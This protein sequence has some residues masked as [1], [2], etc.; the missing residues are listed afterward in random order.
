MT[1]SKSPHHDKNAQGRVLD[2]A[3]RAAVVQTRD[4]TA[5]GVHTQVLTRLVRAGSLERVGPGRYRLA[6]AAVTKHH[7]LVLASAAAASGVI[8]LLSALQFHNIGTQLPHQVWIAVPTGTRVPRLSFPPLR[9]VRISSATFSQGIEGHRLEGHAVRV[10][11]LT[12]TVAD[13]FRF[14][15]TIGL[16]VALEALKEAWRSGR[17]NLDELHRV[18]KQLRV[19]RVMQPYLE[20]IVL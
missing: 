2:L 8:C 16:D 5:A 4:A 3:R 13:C 19:N 1:V 15:N 14:R 17:L 20:T 18:A 6:N 9:V 12:R 7:N 10:Y 11:S